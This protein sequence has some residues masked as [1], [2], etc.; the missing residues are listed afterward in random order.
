LRLY[1]AAAA[2]KQAKTA[3]DAAT[4]EKRAKA[5]AEKEAKVGWCKFEPIEGLKPV[6]N[7]PAFSAPKQI[8]IICF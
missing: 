6:F 3:A 2:D 4:V 5:A 7:A 8:V 1:T